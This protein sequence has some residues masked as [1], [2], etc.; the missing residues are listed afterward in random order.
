MS[1]EK[2]LRFRILFLAL[3]I[4]GGAIAM[5]VGL[6]VSDRISEFSSGYLSGLGAGLIAGSLV[7]LIRTLSLLK[8]ELKRRAK[9]IDEEDERNHI[10]N[11]TSSHIA[12]TAMQVVLFLA[13][14]ICAFYNEKLLN[15]FVSIILLSALVKIVTYAILRKR[16]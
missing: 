10:L 3:T 1:Y 6:L 5:A 12:F 8:N 16:M 15:L 11:I 14:I 9:R 4:L 13:T 2:R 7:I